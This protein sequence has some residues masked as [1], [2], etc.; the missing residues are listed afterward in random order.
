MVAAGLGTGPCV[1]TVNADT[2]VTALFLGTPLSVTLSILKTGNGIGL[3][4]C[5]TDEGTLQCFCRPVSNW[6]P[7]VLQALGS[8]GSTFIGW[9]NG[10]GNAIGCSNT[11][12]DCSMTL[13]VPRWSPRPSS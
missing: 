11:L 12:A 7:L 5:S 9:I 4:T 2:T 1:V 8:S 3:I 13:T 10:T 6:T